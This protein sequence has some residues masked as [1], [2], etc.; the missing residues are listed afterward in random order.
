MALPYT[1]FDDILSL[2]AIPCDE[3]TAVTNPD[4]LGVIISA[5]LAVSIPNH[6]SIK[7]LTGGMTLLKAWANTYGAWM[8]LTLAPQLVTVSSTM[9][10]D[11]LMKITPPLKTLLENLANQYTGFAQAANKLYESSIVLTPRAVF[12]GFGA[13]KPVYDPI[14]GRS[15]DS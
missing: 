2:L 10:G 8:M 7:T 13:A 5:E 15:V 6:A 12:T 4:A 3:A 9:R 11:T 1:T 14:T